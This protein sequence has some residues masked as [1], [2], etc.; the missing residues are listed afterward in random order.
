ML[1]GLFACLKMCL[2][3]ESADPFSAPKDWGHCHFYLFFFCFLVLD[4]AFSCL[5]NSCSALTMHRW[6]VFGRVLYCFSALLLSVPS[7]QLGLDVAFREISLWTADHLVED[8]LAQ[9]R[10]SV[11]VVCHSSTVLF[12]H[13][14]F[15]LS[16]SLSLSLC[17]SLSLKTGLF[18]IVQSL[19]LKRNK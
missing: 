5:S 17:L 18:A 13:C 12:S 3:F 14:P 9:Q 2:Y 8:W 11:P 6:G 7:Q 1:P 4:L 10:Q 16:V 19:W 15:C